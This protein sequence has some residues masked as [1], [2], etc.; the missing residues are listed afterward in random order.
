MTTTT[1]IVGNV[2]MIKFEDIISVYSG[3]K[4]KG[5]WCGCSGIHRTS[6]VNRDA[7]SKERGY[8]Y[9]VDEINDGLV[10]KILGLLQGA[11]TLEWESNCVSAEL[12]QRVYAIY[13]SS[14][15]AEKNLISISPVLAVA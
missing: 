14:E 10:R 5:C 3:R 4:D 11:L 12:G 15:W 9:D 13:F 2:N 7:A 1:K 6:K 8:V